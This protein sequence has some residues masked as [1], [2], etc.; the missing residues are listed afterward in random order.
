MRSMD[1][2]NQAPPVEVPRIQDDP[3]AAEMC[4]VGPLRIVLVAPPYFDVPPT[5][6]G[7]V[8]TVVADIRDRGAVRVWLFLATEHSAGQETL[9]AIDASGRLWPELLA[10]T[11]DHQR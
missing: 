7:G 10:G 1:F 11:S 9:T 4:R 8:E 2:I 5:G 6:Y 3:L